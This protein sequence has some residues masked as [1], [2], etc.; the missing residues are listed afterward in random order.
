MYVYVYS[1]THVY[2]YIYA[3]V[4]IRAVASAGSWCQAGE[5]AGA[6]H[7]PPAPA[8]PR[9]GMITCFCNPWK[10]S[11]RSSPGGNHLNKSKQVLLFKQ[12]RTDTLLAQTVSNPYEA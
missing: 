3:C 7:P 10:V 11:D 2:M 12:I 6:R 8:R 5:L 9:D 4:R 1:Y